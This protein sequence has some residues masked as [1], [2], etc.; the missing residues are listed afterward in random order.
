M[1]WFFECQVV[2]FDGFIGESGRA[3]LSLDTKRSHGGMEALL[4]ETGKEGLYSQREQRNRVTG[5]M[6]SDTMIRKICP[7]HTPSFMVLHE[8]K[9]VSVSWEVG[10]RA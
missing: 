5:T 8:G 4:G 7:N 3:G 6:S 10:D 1:T 2:F 9:K